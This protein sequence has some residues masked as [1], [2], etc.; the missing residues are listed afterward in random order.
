LRAVAK[1]HA[2]FVMRG[3]HIALRG[4]SQAGSAPADVRPVPSAEF[5]AKYE[6]VGHWCPQGDVVRA[7]S[8]AV[9]SM[10]MG[11]DAVAIVEL[12]GAG[13]A[14]SPAWTDVQIADAVARAF[15]V[16]HPEDVAA[17]VANFKDVLQ[18][19]GAAS[20]SSGDPA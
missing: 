3:Q 2:E 12:R 15:N 18:E 20:P 17:G 13:S 9:C 10:C 6:S 7:Y 4:S 5:L 14:G 16:E 8:F 11:K 19:L 1:I